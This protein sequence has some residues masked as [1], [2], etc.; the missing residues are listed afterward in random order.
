MVYPAKSYIWLFMPLI[1]ILL[2]NFY[3]P[4]ELCG[5]KIYASQYF[6]K[7][8]KQFFFWRR[9]RDGGHLITGIAFQVKLFDT[10]HLENSSSVFVDNKM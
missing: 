7:H 6:S 4:K 3:S 1:L 10:E 9:S 5:V 2:N 8:P